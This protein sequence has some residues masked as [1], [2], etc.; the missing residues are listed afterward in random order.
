[1]VHH[2]LDPR[3][4]ESAVGGLQSVT[5]AGSDPAWAEVWSKVLFVGGRGTIADDARS[6]GMA[7]WWVAD[8]GT[9]EMTA[10]A[11]ARTVWVAAEDAPGKAP[12]RPDAS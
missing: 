5:V 9:L 6:R 10:D 8:D 4:G 12:G 1:M 2:L 7:V 3:T 11:R